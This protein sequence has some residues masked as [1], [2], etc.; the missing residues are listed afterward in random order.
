MNG[1]PAI[2]IQVFKTSTANVIETVDKIKALLPILRASISPAINITVAVDRTTTIR[3]SVKSVTN[4]LILSVL[5]VIVVVFAFLREVRSTLIPSVSVPLS[6]LGTCGILY[7]LGYT[8]DNLSLMALTIVTGFVVDDAIVV[9]ENITRHLEAG[10]TP[11]DA[12]M[13][14]SKEIGFTVVSMSISLIAVF[15]PLLLMGGIVG[16]LFREFAIT[17]AAAILVSLAVSL[18]TTPML[19]AKFLKSHNNRR[20][21]WIYR[22]GDR[23]LK[24]LAAEYQRGLRWVLRHQGV[25]LTVL[26]LTIGLNFYLFFLIPKGFFPETDNGRLNGQ[27]RGQQ[28]ASFDTMKKKT[29]QIAAIVGQDRAVAITTAFLGGG[30]P[31]GGGGF[32][33]N[34]SLTLLPDNVRAKTGDNI[35]VVMTR[36]RAKTAGIPG[37]QFLPRSPQELN[38]GARGSATQYQ[39]S[40]TSD[41]LKDLNAW[42]PRLMAAMQKL[43]AL[44]DVATDQMDQGLRAQLVIDR[45]TASRL[46]VS[47]LTIDATLS[48]AFGQ[49]QI[50]TTYMPLNQYHVVMEV[51]PQFQT[52]PDALKNIYVKSTTG[53]EGTALRR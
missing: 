5:L 32:T 3:A 9:L 22:S 31:G 36:L 44:K 33:G 50:S 15:I 37:A 25:M 30:G 27:V 14:G 45:D 46:G 49:K 12:A 1:R 7:V 13:V 51:A 24:T 35:N 19:A 21:S 6:L 8:L 43:P 4:T 11:Y 29:E 40:L 23:V 17:L 38:I 20:R 28:D 2:Q 39:Y 42:A 53:E 10:L 52:D 26:M 34:V 18:T 16:R 47:P 48:D 41:S